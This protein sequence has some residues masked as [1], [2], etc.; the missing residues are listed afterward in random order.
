MS[1]ITPLAASMK[2][3]LLQ[4]AKQALA[5]GTGLQNAA[6]GGAPGG[7]AQYLLKTY[8]SLTKIADECDHQFLISSVSDQQPPSEI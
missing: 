8:E 4:I 3:T 2:T 6:P 1:D 5:L 7:S